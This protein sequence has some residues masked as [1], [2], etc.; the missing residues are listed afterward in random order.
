MDIGKKI[1]FLRKQK[2]VTQAQLAEYLSVTPQSVSRWE[3]N[4]GVPDIYLLPSIATFFDVSIEELYGIHDTEK[5]TKLVYK[6]SILRDEKSYEDAMAAIENGINSTPDGEGY[7]Q[8][9]AQKMHMYLQK[10]REYIKKADEVADILLEKTQEPENPLHMPVRFQKIQFA[11]LQ[12]KEQEALTELKNNFENHPSSEN[13]L[14][15]MC[16]LLETYRYK[17]ILFLYDNSEVKRLIE[18][19]S[20]TTKQIYDF[21]FSAAEKEN[22]LSF[23][24][25]HF[26]EFERIA[27]PASV[28]SSRIGYAKV[29]KA[30]CKMDELKTCKEKMLGEISIHQENELYLNLLVEKI[31]NI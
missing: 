2:N 15:Y 29:L 18:D 1:A 5:I 12:G 22:D 8:L 9:L 6:Y 11:V 7:Q 13:I 10:S 30:H 16:I 23:F 3:S 20:N 24:Q 26:A 28:L 21:L 19:G 14:L 25:S 27:D 31:R 4:N 17:E